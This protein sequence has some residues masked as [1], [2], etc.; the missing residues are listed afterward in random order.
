MLSVGSKLRWPGVFYFPGTL[1]EPEGKNLAEAEFSQALGREDRARTELQ[2]KGRA[3][4]GESAPT[5]SRGD[6]DRGLRA[7]LRQSQHWWERP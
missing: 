7:L 5:A 6:Q 3:R 2:G 1:G 4:A